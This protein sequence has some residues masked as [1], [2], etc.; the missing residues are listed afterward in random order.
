M[1]VSCPPIC[2][3]TIVA[4]ALWGGESLWLREDDE[5]FTIQDKE[6]VI[7]LGD[8][9]LSCLSYRDKFQFP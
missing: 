9:L 5:C 1:I 2:Q 3:N 4:Q 6:K 8:I 7:K